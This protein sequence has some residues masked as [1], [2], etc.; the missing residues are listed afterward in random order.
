MYEYSRRIIDDGFINSFNQS[1][2]HLKTLNLA[3]KVVFIAQTTTLT[4]KV[5]AAIIGR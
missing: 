2:V 1:L 3:L 4:V 5:V